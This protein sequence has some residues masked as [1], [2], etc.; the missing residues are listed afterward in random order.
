MRDF[1]RENERKRSRERERTVL[2]RVNNQRFFPGSCTFRTYLHNSYH[3]GLASMR[4]PSSDVRGLAA[5]SR[6]N[7]ILL[8]SRDTS[9]RIDQFYGE[10]NRRLFA[11]DIDNA[12]RSCALLFFL[13]FF[14]VKVC[15][16]FS[17][18]QPLPLV[19]NWFCSCDSC[20]WFS[21]TGKDLSF[22]LC[23]VIS[24]D[25]EFFRKVQISRRKELQIVSFLVDARYDSSSLNFLRV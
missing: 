3:D 17:R 2:G 22:L 13:F 10:N 23:R 15:R 14:F 18:V 12:T 4:N 25:S 11:S 1:S 9:R 21:G 6:R 24:C 8:V 19:Q 5:R 7:R 20:S 16:R